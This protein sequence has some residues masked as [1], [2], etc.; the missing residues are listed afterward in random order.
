MTSLSDK[1][2]CDVKLTKAIAA[3]TLLDKMWNFGHKQ[4][5]DMIDFETHQYATKAIINNP[6]AKEA[7]QFL[8]RLKGTDRAIAQA[9]DNQALKNWFSK[10]ETYINMFADPNLSKLP[11]PSSE[12]ERMG[13]FLARQALDHYTLNFD[14]A[15]REIPKQFNPTMPNEI[16]TQLPG[17]LTPRP[18]TQVREK[19]GTELS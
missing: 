7:F 11:K 13:N 14:K 18:Y 10:R 1:K 2:E 17:E 3:A 4:Y 8:E 19:S 12:P 5:N 15:C 16:R 9:S 6:Q